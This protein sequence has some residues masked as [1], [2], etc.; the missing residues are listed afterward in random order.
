LGQNYSN[1]LS[2]RKDLLS[3]EENG[4]MDS[5]SCSRS[6]FLRTFSSFS[7]ELTLGLSHKQLK[8]LILSYSV[9]NSNNNN[10][11]EDEEKEMNGRKEDVIVNCQ[12]LCDHIFDASLNLCFDYSSSSTSEGSRNNTR[13]PSF[14]SHSSS[15]GGFNTANNS[16]SNQNQEYDQSAHLSD[17]NLITLCKIFHSK[18]VSGGTKRRRI[19]SL[20]L[21]HDIGSSTPAFISNPPSPRSRG[22][23]QSVFRRHL[24]SK[25]SFEQIVNLLSMEYHLEFIEQEILINFLFKTPSSTINYLDF[26]KAIIMR[27]VRLLRKIRGE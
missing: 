19:E 6:H 24:L 18:F 11:G 12:L 21:S 4:L 9:V 22:R 1:L 16:F 5:S 15:R 25:S 13:S 3:E 17:A 14:S 7:N 27:N 26:V 20:F 8:K 23:Q 2:L 10:D